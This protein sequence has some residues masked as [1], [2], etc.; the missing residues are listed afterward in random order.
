MSSVQVEHCEGLPNSN[1]REEDEEDVNRTTEII[2]EGEH[3]GDQ[4]CTLKNENTFSLVYGNI[5]TLP[6]Y[7]NNPKMTHLKTL[8]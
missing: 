7:N 5:N 8:S 2:H 1:I 6:N 3:Y 4:R